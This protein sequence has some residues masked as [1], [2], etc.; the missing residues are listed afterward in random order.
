MTRIEW[1]RPFERTFET[2]LDRGVI[3]L[4]EGRAV[5]WNGLVRVTTNQNQ[6]IESVFYEG[7]K[8]HDVVSLGSFSGSIEALTYPSDFDSVHGRSEILG[9][10]HAFEQPSNRFGLSYR[11]YVGDAVNGPDASYK[12]H[13]IYN[14]SAVPLDKDELSLSEEPEASLFEW[15]ISAVPEYLDGFR[16]AAHIVIDT[17]RVD[18]YLLEK[19]ESLLYGDDTT[20]PQLPSLPDLVRYIR[21][22]FRVYIEDN[23]DGTWTAREADFV[24]GY[25]HEDDPEPEM[26]TI[27]SANIEW[28]DEH[29]F[30]IW[31]SSKPLRDDEEPVDPTPDPEDTFTDVFTDVY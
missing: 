23:G 15:E 9:G 19:L 7:V 6:D 21:S 14:V 18:E 4:P 28:L 20:P 5:P 2:G 11:T 1:D 27:L 29:T 8:A 13:L 10:V 25:I 22:W 12:I 17:K 24:E 30:R 3:Y 16:P 26:F 31:D